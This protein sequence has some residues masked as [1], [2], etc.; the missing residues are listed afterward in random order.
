MWCY[1]LKLKMFTPLIFLDEY[2]CFQATDEKS[3]TECMFRDGDDGGVIC[4][5]ECS[6]IRATHQFFHRFY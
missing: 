2:V 3:V 4:Y 1:N 5:H 6:V